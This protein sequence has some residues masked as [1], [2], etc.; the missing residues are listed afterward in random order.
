M[1]KL[2]SKYKNIYIFL[3]TLSIIGIISGYIYYQIQPKSIKTEIKESFEIKENLDKRINNT[4]RDIPPALK[5]II[6]S[7]L[8]IPIIISI[9]HIFYKPFEI[10]FI[11]NLLSA[12]NIKLSII[13][14][15]TYLI[16]PFI[17]VLFLT[18]ISITFSYNLYKHILIRDTKSKS[19][20]KSSIKKYLL[21][22]FFLLIYEILIIIISPIINSYLMTFL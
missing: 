14:S 2:L 11:F 19:I 3:I 8:V 16:I 22:T 17:I 12:Y 20:Y 1:T 10:G 4:K 13:Y 7:I 18:R 15:L 9:F 21:L 6:S 5:I